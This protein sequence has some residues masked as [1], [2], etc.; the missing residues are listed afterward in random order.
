MS[1]GGK[2]EGAGSKPRSLSPS[3]NRS[4]KF[5]DDEWKLIALYS[6]YFNLT[7]SEY[8]RSRVLY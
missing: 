3:K 2:R 5:T 7:M 1:S 8:I 6:K 4:I